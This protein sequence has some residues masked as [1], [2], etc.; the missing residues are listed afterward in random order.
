MLQTRLLQSLHT[1]KHGLV[2]NFFFLLFWAM[3][4]YCKEF[5]ARME[6]LWCETEMPPPFGA[7]RIQNFACDAVPLVRWVC[8]W[9]HVSHQGTMCSW[10]R[11]IQIIWSCEGDCRTNF[12]K[13]IKSE[14]LTILTLTCVISFLDTFF[15][16]TCWFH[17]FSFFLKDT[18][19]YIMKTVLG[20]GFCHVWK[21][22]NFCGE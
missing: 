11:M 14:C 13:G 19:T 6:T 15:K 1:E 17:A 10:K 20:K 12:L 4:L 8:W 16:A 18:Y 3:L 21:Y 9:I 7:S 5:M 22:F 2:K